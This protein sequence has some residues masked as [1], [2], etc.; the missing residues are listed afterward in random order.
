[1]AIASCLSSSSSSVAAP[2]YASGPA[3][4]RG[5]KAFYHLCAAQPGDSCSFLPT[6]SKEG[7]TDSSSGS[8]PRLAPHPLLQH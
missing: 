8:A 2:C 3:A 7:R 6:S 5:I 4:T 1:M